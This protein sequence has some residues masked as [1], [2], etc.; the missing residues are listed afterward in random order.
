MFCPLL[1]S[2]GGVCLHQLVSLTCLRRLKLFTY[3]LTKFRMTP[4][5]RSEITQSP[6]TLME[7]SLFVKCRG[8]TLNMFKLVSKRENYC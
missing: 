4:Q 3:D 8:T 7:N 2:E 6:L 5:A 1:I